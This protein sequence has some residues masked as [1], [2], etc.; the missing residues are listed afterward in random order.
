MKPHCRKARRA[1]LQL[2]WIGAAAIA[3][4][5]CQ[6]QPAEKT[7]ETPHPQQAGQPVN[8]YVAAGHV[9]GARAALLVGDSRAADQQINAV[10]QD[11]SRSARIRDVN[12]SVNH[13]AARA[14]VRPLPGVRSG[15]WFDVVVDGQK[16]RTMGMIDR[17][18]VALATRGAWS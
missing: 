12:R 2:A 15:I 5:A 6:Q 3:T 9:A 4:A 7:A 18:C 13:E 10:A 17:V 11:F 1:L 16:H 14:A 8:P